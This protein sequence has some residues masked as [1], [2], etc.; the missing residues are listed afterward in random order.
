MSICQSLCNSEGHFT[1]Q[2]WTQNTYILKSTIC[3]TLCCI[4]MPFVQLDLAESSYT[5]LKVCQIIQL[6]L[7]LEATMRLSEAGYLL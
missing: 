2:W 6:M 4:H 3:Y 5:K 7:S 1:V